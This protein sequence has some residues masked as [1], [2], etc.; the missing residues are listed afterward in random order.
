M[1]K[2]ILIFAVLAFLGFI[3]SFYIRKINPATQLVI[4]GV[5]TLYSLVSYFVLSEKSFLFLT[6][7][8]VSWGID[9][10]KKIRAKRFFDKQN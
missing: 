5:L 9:S 1:D 7:L 2:T 6:I 8:S 10:I 3:A 4:A